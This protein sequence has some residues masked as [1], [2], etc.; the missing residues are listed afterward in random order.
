MVIFHSYVKLPEGSSKSWKNLLIRH[1]LVPRLPETA[2]S[3]AK[4]K[5][6]RQDS[7]WPVTVGTFSCLLVIGLLTAT[8]KRVLYVS[9]LLAFPRLWHCP[10]AI[11]PDARPPGLLNT[12]NEN[13]KCELL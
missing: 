7:G 12:E 1:P 4:G 2:L 13:H 11:L 6:T 8:S 10:H 5:G 3:W 9:E